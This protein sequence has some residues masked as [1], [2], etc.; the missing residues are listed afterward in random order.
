[1]ADIARA[2]QRRNKSGVYRVLALSG[3]ITPSRRRR[4]AMALTLAEREEISRGLAVGSSIRA[5][6]AQLR[7]AA[8]TVSREVNRHGGRGAYRA[9]DAEG[10]AGERAHRPKPCRLATHP[11]LRWGVAQKRALEWSPEQ[12]AGGLKR[13]YPGHEGWQVSHESIDRS[14]LVQTRGVLKKELIAHLRSGR[15]IRQAKGGTTKIGLGSLVAMR[16]RSESGRPRRKIG[17]S[18]VTGKAIYCAEPTTRTSPHWSSGGCKNFC[19]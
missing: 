6:A 10:S 1:M 18:R 2:L 15:N 7:R 4:S 8:S 9:S 5:I 11:G 19:V 13:T 12:I 16:C 17:R 14:L 3:G